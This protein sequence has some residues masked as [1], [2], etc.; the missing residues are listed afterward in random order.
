MVVLYTDGVTEM[1]NEKAEEYGLQRLNKL[2]VENE[3]T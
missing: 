1:R 2:V 3:F